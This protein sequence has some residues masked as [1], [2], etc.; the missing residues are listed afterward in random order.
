MVRSGKNVFFTGGAGTGKSFLIQKIIGVLPPDHTFITAST[1]VA[2]FQVRIY[3]F[4]DLLMGWGFHLG[5]LG[6][7]F[8]IYIDLPC[9]F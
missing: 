2:A 6:V 4:I 5:I 7:S 8:D 9:L 1:G 3:A